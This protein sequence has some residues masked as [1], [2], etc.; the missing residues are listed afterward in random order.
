MLTA[1]QHVQRLQHGLGGTP[2]SR[3]NLYDTLNMGG[4]RLVDEYGWSW[5]IKRVT[6]ATVEDQDYIDL[7]ED[8]GGLVKCQA[9]ADGTMVSVQIVSVDELTEMRTRNINGSGAGVLYGSFMG[10]R[11]GS[12]VDRM[13][14][15]LWPTPTDDDTAIELVYLRKWVELAVGDPDRIPNIPPSFE[16]AL[17]LAALEV[18]FRIQQ[19]TTGKAEE[20]EAALQRVLV[21]MREEDGRRQPSTGKRMR[22]G[23]GDFYQ[24]DMNRDDPGIGNIG[25]LSV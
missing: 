22:G 25:I 9:S 13:A 21:R 7:P 17:A 6:L 24:P 2:D 11:S 8:F 12:P 16:Y 5:R 19:P 20:T 1:A 4:R 3:H 18:G 10:S 23:V 14:L 15:W